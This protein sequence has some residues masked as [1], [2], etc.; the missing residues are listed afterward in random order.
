M[1]WVRPSAS[2]QTAYI[3][4]ITPR[5]EPNLGYAC[6]V[7]SPPASRIY[8]NVGV[9]SEEV[10]RALVEVGLRPGSAAGDLV[11]EHG[12]IKAIAG[13]HRHPL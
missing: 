9:T 11:I 8:R 1:P 12:A 5:R 7:R 2:L 6:Y 3:Y 13:T 10:A 4:P